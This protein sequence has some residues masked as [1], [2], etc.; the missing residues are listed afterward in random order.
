MA[1][2]PQ[3]KTKEMW[4][5]IREYVGEF[6]R[7]NGFGPTL[8]DI[9]M[10][11]GLSSPS[12]AKYHVDRMLDAGELAGSLGMARTLNVPDWR[13]ESSVLPSINFVKVPMLGPIGAATDFVVP[14]ARSADM[15]DDLDQLDIPEQ[16][17]GAADKVFALE[18][19]GDSMIDALVSDGDTVLIQATRAVRRGDTVAA[20][21]SR[22]GEFETTTLKRYY[23]HREGKIRLQPAHP[24][25][26]DIIVDA[27]DCDIQGKAIA[28]LRQY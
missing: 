18:V 13:E 19:K 5:R 14:D 22:N 24:E 9:Q 27:K 15:A 1:T 17:I 4:R 11:I 23:P 2:K 16:M 8:R 20:R 3:R 25:M 28:V 26:D 12:N 7:E 10:E 6:H 21:I